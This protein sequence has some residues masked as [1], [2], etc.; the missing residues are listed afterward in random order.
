MFPLI[1]QYLKIIFARTPFLG[2][3]YF[4]KY[5]YRHGINAKIIQG[6][7]QNLGHNIDIYQSRGKPVPIL[8]LKEFEF[9]IG[10]LQRNGIGVDEATAWALE[11][12]VVGKYNLKKNLKP[13]QNLESIG[14]EVLLEHAIVQRRSIRKWTNAPL[15]FVEIERAVEIAK[16]A[17]SSCNRQTWQIMFIQK[18]EDR[19]FLGK[20]FPNNFWL[21]A[22]LLAL[23]LADSDMYG[24]N[25]KHFVYLD[26]AA[27]I[28]NYLLMLH[29]M[30]YGACWLGFKGWDSC[31]NV[32][33]DDQEREDFYMFFN[34][35]RT[36]VPISMIAIGR[37]ALTP[38]APPRQTIEK[39][40]IKRE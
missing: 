22:P 20:Y 5:V 19:K 33:V 18:E 24:K 27:F 9:L 26:G 17:P 23:V 3:L 37:P 36:M 4:R 34:F 1:K 25:E 32:Y 14:K 7:I 2:G 21:E 30:G 11:W 10:E 13:M 12:Y 31:D 35:K 16:W 8:L 40:L 6:K 28:Q 15:S 39:I 38:K 29:A